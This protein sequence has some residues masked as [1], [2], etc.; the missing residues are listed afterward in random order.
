[1]PEEILPNGMTR[2]SLKHL[3]FITLTV[4]IDYKGDAAG[5]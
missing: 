2:A 5:T 3:L 1:M 4:A